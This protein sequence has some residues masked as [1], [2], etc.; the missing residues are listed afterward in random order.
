MGT[1]SHNYG[2]NIRADVNNLYTEIAN[3]DRKIET[4]SAV[5]KARINIAPITL[6]AISATTTFIAFVAPVN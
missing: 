2:T 3:I 1:L 6:G 5:E 4:V